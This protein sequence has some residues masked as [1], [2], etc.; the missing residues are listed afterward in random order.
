MNFIAADFGEAAAIFHKRI[1]VFIPYTETMGAKL[2]Y[3]AAE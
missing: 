1:T 2:P 3:K